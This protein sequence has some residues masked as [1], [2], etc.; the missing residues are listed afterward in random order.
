M[1]RQDQLPDETVLLAHDTMLMYNRPMYR[2]I[3][4]AICLLA[5]S[6]AAQPDSYLQ[7][8]PHVTFDKENVELQTSLYPTYYRTSAA[9]DDQRWVATHTVELDSFWQQSGDSVLWILSELAGIPWQRQELTIT[10][11]RYYPTGGNPDPLILPISGVRVGALAEAIP[12]GP[13][14]Q[15]NLIYQLAHRLLLEGERTRAD[16]TSTLQNHPLA[17]PGPYYR[18]LL[19]FHLAYSTARIVIG[20][21]STLAAYQSPFWK[22]SFPGRELYEQYLQSA[23]I[24]TP[25]KPLLVWL[26]KEA[27][28]SR[29]VQAVSPLANQDVGQERRQTVDGMP[30]KGQ[31]GFSVRINDNN[32]LVIDKIDNTRLAYKAGLRT[33]D[34]IA[35]VGGTRPRTHKELM[36]MLFDGLERGSI[37]VQVTRAGKS[38]TMILRK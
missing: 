13:P 17:Q 30:T 23:W 5:A 21:D 1:A 26:G 37:A 19:A 4:I 18:D 36:E 20:P 12:A 27:T 14:T 38:E 25:E 29:L 8:R 31:I 32:M 11:L 34:I 10:L 24:L 3:L 28:D 35:R 16:L 6:L 22:T 2:F 9:V 15:L 33:G 7:S